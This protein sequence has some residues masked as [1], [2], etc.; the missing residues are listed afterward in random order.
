MLKIISSLM[1][2]HRI[3]LFGALKLDDCKITKPYLLK[4]NNIASGT[5]IIFAVPYLSR[6][7]TGGN[8]SEYAKARDY[9]LFFKLFSDDIIPRLR[10]AFPENNFA[11]FSDHSPID[12]I[13]AAAKCGIGII[14][15]HG[16]L[17]TERYSSFVFIGEIITDLK[18]E[19]QPSKIKTCEGCGLCERECPV[20]LC[21]SECLSAV[22]QKKGDL[23]DSD[24]EL[25]TKHST[26]WGCD[27]CQ[28]A[29]IHTKRCIQ[30]GTIYSEIPFF[31]QELTPEIT[32][33]LIQN[34][35]DE[36]FS[37]RAYSWRG[38]Q[39]ILRNL[40]AVYKK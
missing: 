20:F 4:N 23:S 12:E 38:R 21:K 33:E 7:A 17:I 1:A 34:M 31:N 30:N 22:T 11:V 40:M 2:E 14:G 9:H 16:L 37:C 18:L 6:S 24:I 8:I 25:M 13:E 10:S 15:K 39:T 29:C 5:A 36:E 28:K 3:E 32:Y 19:C 26:I 35:S 27:I